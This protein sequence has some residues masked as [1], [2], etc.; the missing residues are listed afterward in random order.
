MSHPPDDEVST[1]I[2]PVKTTGNSADAP[3]PVRPTSRATSTPEIRRWS[4]SSQSWS[5]SPVARRSNVAPG[6]RST[7]N[8]SLDVKSPTSRSTSG[9]TG[10]RLSSVT[11]TVN[12]LAR[13]HR[14]TTSA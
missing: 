7:L 4:R 11:F 14:A 3:R 6:S 5:R 12:G 1:P 9:C 10:I 2:I 8:K 13:V